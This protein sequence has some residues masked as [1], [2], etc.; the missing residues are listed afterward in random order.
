MAT[1]QPAQP[2]TKR[3]KRT[4]VSAIYEILTISSAGADDAVQKI[5][6]LGPSKSVVRLALSKLHAAK[7]AGFAETLLRAADKMGYSFRG[8]TYVVGKNKRLIIPVGV[9]FS[10]GTRVVVD[11]EQGKITVRLA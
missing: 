1:K 4:T 2:A 3:G 8:T 9:A 6:K 5:T 11:R 10:A 7:Q